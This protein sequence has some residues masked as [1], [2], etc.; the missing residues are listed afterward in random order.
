MKIP[1][2]LRLASCAVLI[3]A[4]SGCSDKLDFSALEKQRDANPV[5]RYDAVQALARNAD[6]WLAGTQNGALIASKDGK[7]WSRIT[8][9]MGSSIVA[10]AGCPDGSWLAGDFFGRVFAAASLQGPWQPRPIADFSNVLSLACPAAGQWVVAGSH[11]KVAQSSDGG[12]SWQLSE[13][14]E[15]GAHLSALSFV[16]AKTGYVAGEFGEVYRSDDGGLS[17]TPLSVVDENFYPYAAHFTTPDKG[18]LVGIAGKSYRTEDAGASWQEV[19]NLTG[20]PMFALTAHRQALY[21]SGAEGRVAVL[22]DGVWRDYSALDQAPLPLMSA[23]A[24]DDMLLVGSVAG[25]L[26]SVPV[27]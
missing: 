19:S 12:A 15:Q 18:V 25:L 8:L 23:A 11:G 14:G 26:R 17:W 3:A 2:A 6:G 1:G 16:D 13:L 7:Q 20:V 4:L 5:R 10:V 27:K 22:R 9:P 21:A 24:G